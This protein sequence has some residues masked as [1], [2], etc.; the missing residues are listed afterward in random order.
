MGVVEWL[1]GVA[2]LREGWPTIRMAEIIHN[3]CEVKGSLAI[4]LLRF[5]VGVG[6]L[7][8]IRVCTLTL[9]VRIRPIRLA[10]SFP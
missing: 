1:R 9:S 10:L 6:L 7:G 8:I 2:S 4:W 5:V 3:C